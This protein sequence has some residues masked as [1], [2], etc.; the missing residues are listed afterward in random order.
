MVHVILTYQYWIRYRIKTEG[1]NIGTFLNLK[2]IMKEYFEKL[3]SVE[4]GLIRQSYMSL[5]RTKEENPIRLDYELVPAIYAMMELIISF[6]IDCGESVEKFVEQKLRRNKKSKEWRH[7][8]RIYDKYA[9]N[10]I[11]FSAKVFS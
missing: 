4:Y 7:F 11:G 1:A 10:K 3:I 9:I 6:E 8:A 5:T 2:Y